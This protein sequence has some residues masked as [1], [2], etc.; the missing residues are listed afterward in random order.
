MSGEASHLG[1]DSQYVQG[2]AGGSEGSNFMDYMHSSENSQELHCLR[3]ALTLPSIL[4]DH[5]Q[6]MLA[7][8][9]RGLGMRLIKL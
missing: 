2:L 7:V 3:H 8:N 1:G 5:L 9:I 4:G 6:L